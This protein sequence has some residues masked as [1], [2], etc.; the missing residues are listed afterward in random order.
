MNA[1]R[2][3]VGVSGDVMSACSSRM[4][5]CVGVGHD[6]GEYAGSAA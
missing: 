2:I 1:A 5:A 6:A 4:G 3:M